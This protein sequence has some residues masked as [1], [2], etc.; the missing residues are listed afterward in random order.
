MDPIKTAAVI[1]DGGM[2]TAMACLLAGRGLRVVLWGAFPDYSAEVARTRLNPK[3]LPGVVLPAAIEVT[4]DA[5]RIP[6]DTDLVV[7]AVPTQFLRGVL[8]RIGRRLPERALYV[9]VA[10]GLEVGTLLRPSEIVGAALGRRTFA[11]LSGPSHAEEV[12]RNLPVTIVAA[13]GDESAAR[14]VQETFRTERFRVYTSGDLAGV[15]LGGAVKNVIAIAAGI[16]DG[17]GLGDSA[18]AALMT[19][20]SVE[21]ARLGQACGA[22]PATFSGLTGIGD[23]IVTCTSRHSRNRAVGEAIGRGE[24][25]AQVLAR[26]VQVAEGVETTKSARALARRHAVEMPITEAVH[27]VLFEDKPPLVAVTDLMLRPPRPE[28]AT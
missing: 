20:G 8:T 9:S 12:A 24:T 27:A 4:G 11:A 15:E 21:M 22:E 26:M 7:L 10:K 19:R 1:G 3:F 16:S 14:L 28:T 17:L 5:T 23:L 6:G 2:G 18:K 13:S 25:L